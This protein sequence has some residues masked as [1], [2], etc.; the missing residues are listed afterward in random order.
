VEGKDKKLLSEEEKRKKRARFLP[1]TSLR[2]SILPAPSAEKQ[3]WV[4]GIG[5]FIFKKKKNQKNAQT[6]NSTP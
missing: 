2:T 1:E 6:K 5:E 4:T 3:L